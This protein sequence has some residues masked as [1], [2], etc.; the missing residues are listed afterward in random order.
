[1]QKNVKLN[2]NKPKRKIYEFK[3]RQSFRRSSLKDK[4]IANKL[5]NN[6][7]DL[8]IIFERI[9]EINVN[10]RLKRKD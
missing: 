1:M 9:E 5:N 3:N 10:K 7:I 4:K 6:I 8:D 2:N